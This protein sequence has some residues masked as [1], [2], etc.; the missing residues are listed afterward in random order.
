MPYDSNNSGYGLM[1]LIR[2]IMAGAEANADAAY[3]QMYGPVLAAIGEPD[4]DQFGGPSDMDADNMAGGIAG[5]MGGGD[6]GRLGRGAGYVGETPSS[7]PYAGLGGRMPARAQMGRPAG[8]AI[9]P[10]PP[11]DMV[12]VPPAQMV[13][14]HAPPPPTRPAIPLGPGYDMVTRPPT[15][16]TPVETGPAPLMRQSAAPLGARTPLAPRIDVTPPPMR[17]GGLPTGT[18]AGAGAAMLSPLA[19]SMLAEQAGNF[20]QTNARNEANRVPDM[21][22]GD[23]TVTTAPR[24][25]GQYASMPVATPPMVPPMAA[26]RQTTGLESALR[27]M[28]NPT[29]LTP[30]DTSP[31]AGLREMYAPNGT[32]GGGAQADLTGAASQLGLSGRASLADDVIAAMLG[33]GDAGIDDL[34]TLQKAAAMRRRPTGAGV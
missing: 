7:G 32:S 4:A 29:A 14:P 1:D 27:A 8:A 12:R 9:P 25:Q 10:S 31:A 23:A 22:A 6:F 28:P 33:G 34:V 24:G 20:F 19:A 5:R 30:M 17:T 3:Q 15:S 26:A 18:M 13:G 2:R 21:V 16:M 11:T